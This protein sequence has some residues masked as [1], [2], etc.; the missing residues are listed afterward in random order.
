MTITLLLRFLR[1]IGGS[2]NSF[3]IYRS[4]A[5]NLDRLEGVIS[6][7][8]SPPFAALIFFSEGALFFG[9]V[10]SPS[11]VFALLSDVTLATGYSAFSTLILLLRSICDSA[12]LNYGILSGS[13]SMGSYLLGP[14]LTVPKAK[15]MNDYKFESNLRSR[16]E[17][18]TPLQLGHDLRGLDRIYFS[19]QSLQN[20]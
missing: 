18:S 6:L 9:R 11:T 14:R 8:E 5:A 7:S 19:I 1:S 17:F 16:L 15:V 4:Y 13:S 2:I 20:L 10:S 12:F 3:F